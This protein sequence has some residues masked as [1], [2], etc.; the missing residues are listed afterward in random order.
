VQHVINDVLA[1]DKDLTGKIFVVGCTVNPGDCQKIQD[2]VRHLGI[3]IL[4]NP[5]F[6]AQGR[7][8]NDLQYADMVLIGGENQEIMDEYAK[9]YDGIQLTSPR[10]NTM[11]LPAAEL[12]KIAINCFLTTKISYANLVGEILLE[13]GL[14]A[15]V[16]KVLKAIG[17]D[18]RIGSKYMNFGFGYGGPCLPRDNRAFAHYANSIGID[19][20]LGQIV[21]DFNKKHSTFLKNYFIKANTNNL[22]FYMKSITYKPNTDIIEES[23]QLALCKDLL[24]EGYVVCVE[25]HRMIPDHLLV[26]LSNT[27]GEN[28]KAI[29]KESLQKNNELFF[30][31]LI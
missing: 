21:D 27:Y 23:Q 6:I 8:I 20:N 17:E 2:S 30:E 13:S 22:P 24:K 11:S 19:F 14:D 15:D 9:V 29:T 3:H 28:F 25:P 16:T 7:I 5:E 18:L 12:T 26:E 1:T 10:V 31:V 4:Y